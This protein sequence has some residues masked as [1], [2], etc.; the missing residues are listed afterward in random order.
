M[1]Q[2]FNTISELLNQFLNHV[3]VN[4]DSFFKFDAF[5]KFQYRG[6]NRKDLPFKLLQPI[7]HIL[8]RVKKIILKWNGNLV[9]CIEKY[10][11]YI[12]LW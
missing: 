10:I 6:M 3:S 11:E 8:S 12:F 1:N 7:C 5:V 9:R 4:I 2:N